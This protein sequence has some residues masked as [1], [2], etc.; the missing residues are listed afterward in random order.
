METTKAAESSIPGHWG[1]CTGRPNRM[2]V[3]KPWFLKMLKEDEVSWDENPVFHPIK[4][5]PVLIDY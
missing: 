2:K 5:A 3:L 1:N 4:R